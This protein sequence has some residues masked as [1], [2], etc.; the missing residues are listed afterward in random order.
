MSWNIDYVFLIL[1]TTIISYGAAIM[2]QRS[3]TQRQKKIY[4]ATSVTA[5]LGV[6]FFYKYFNFLSSSLNDVLNVF[7]SSIEIPYLNLLLPVGISFYTFQTLSYTIDVYRG[8]IETEKHFGIYALYVSFFPQ[9]VAGPIER[10]TRLL[11]QFREKHKLT[12]DNVIKGL[13]W[14]I[15]GFFMKLVIA[16]RLSIYVDSVYNNVYQHDGLTF[17]VATFFFAFQI[18]G[19][20][21][22]YSSIAIGVARIMGFDLMTNFKRPYFATSITDFWRRWHISLSTWFRD[23]FYIPMGGNRVGVSRWYLNL[24]LTFLVSGLWHGANWTFIIWGALHG[25]YIVIENYFKLQVN[26][27]KKIS[28]L[29]RIFRTTVV[30]ILVDLAWVFFRANNVTEAFYV[31]KSIFS[32]SGEV[33]YDI[34]VFFYA[35][36]GLIILFIND[37]VVESNQNSIL[38]NSKIN[39]K[40]TIYFAFLV[41]LILYIGVFNGGQFIYFQF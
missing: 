3:K 20:F 10:S 25:I 12:S 31:I 22:G 30:F 15:F 36:I 28:F 27:D 38:E 32:F 41:C 24:F 16:D 11:P 18:F 5:S 2:I 37:L 8:E 35:T 13:K 7:S 19:D 23:Y 34:K 6:L 33:F 21:A 39:Y 40:V 4:L 9:L 17:I 1:F 26:K 29:S 14:V